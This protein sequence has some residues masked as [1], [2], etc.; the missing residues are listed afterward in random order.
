M[1]IGVRI[2][3]FTFPTSFFSAD[4]QRL[5]HR[6]SPTAPLN[7]VTMSTGGS[8]LRSPTVSSSN[9]SQSMAHLSSHSPMPCHFASPIT[10]TCGVSNCNP[11][12]DGVNLQHHPFKPPSPVARNGMAP[13][14]ITLPG[15]EARC[16]TMDRVASNSPGTQQQQ[17]WG[18]YSTE[19]EEG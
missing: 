14:N 7:H 6:P 3:H 4:H 18:R 17:Q 12:P 8:L 5:F 9:G 15:S 16:S 10:A 19:R 2:A 1:C 11:S 13:G